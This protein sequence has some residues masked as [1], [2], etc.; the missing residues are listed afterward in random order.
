MES[1]ASPCLFVAPPFSSQFI[2]S[3]V[4]PFPPWALHPCCNSITSSSHIWLHLSSIRP[5]RY[6]FSV[7]AYKLF[8]IPDSFSRYVAHFVY[9]KCDI[10]SALTTLT[11]Y[12][13]I[14]VEIKIVEICLSTVCLF[15]GAK[16]LGKRPNNT[17]EWN[18]RD[19]KY[20]LQTLKYT[21]TQCHRYLS[22]IQ[23]I[24]LNSNNFFFTWK[25]DKG[26]GSWIAWC[27][28]TWS[29]IVTEITWWLYLTRWVTLAWCFKRRIPHHFYSFHPSSKFIK[30]LDIFLSVTTEQ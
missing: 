24:T 20:I 21:W 28:W 9:F 7:C 29:H 1:P 18:N 2:L 22:P 4:S 6:Q 8:E 27:F 19:R 23:V 13:S 16:T 14:S 11:L 10:C 30:E 12:A 25:L 15:I 3:F 17:T 5:L 26:G